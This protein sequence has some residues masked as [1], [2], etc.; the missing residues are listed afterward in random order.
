[1][2]DG[3]KAG[4]LVITMTVFGLVQVLGQLSAVIGMGVK[5]EDT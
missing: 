3:R 4:G 5:S 2:D 1:M